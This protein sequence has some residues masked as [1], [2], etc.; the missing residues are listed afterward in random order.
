M[1][2]QH[3]LEQKQIPETDARFGEIPV[4]L[5][6]R[7]MP[8]V[9]VK[10]SSNWVHHNCKI[11][12]TTGSV[13]DTPSTSSSPGLSSSKKR[14]YEDLSLLTEENPTREH[15]SVSTPV[16]NEAEPPAKRQRHFTL[17]S[18]PSTMFYMKHRQEQ[19]LQKSKAH[20]SPFN[21]PA[22][23]SSSQATLTSKPRANQVTKSISGGRYKG[24]AGP[25]KNSTNFL[26]D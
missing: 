14:T 25:S 17:S 11:D 15:R 24:S 16:Q 23:S 4:V 2:S 8:M 3:S 26:K 19:L 18:L 7:G 22:A 10:D 20:H 21:Q 9:F 1:Y 5:N 13:P 12:L 6:L